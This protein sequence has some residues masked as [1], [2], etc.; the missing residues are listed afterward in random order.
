MSQNDAASYKVGEFDYKGTFNLNDSISA[1]L[2]LNDG[3]LLADADIQF[4][5]KFELIDENADKDLWGV[6]IKKGI[7]DA[8]KVAKEGILAVKEEKQAS[9]IDEY[10]VIKVTTTV[11]SQVEGVHDLVVYNYVLVQAIRPT[12]AEN[13]ATV[14]L[15]PLGDATFNLSY[16]TAKQIVKLDV[17]AFEDAIGGRDILTD[18]G[19]S[20][21]WPLYK[22]DYN[23]EKE[24]TGYSEAYDYLTT[25]IL[26]GDRWKISSI[27]MAC[28]TWTRY[29]KTRLNS[30]AR[31]LYARPVGTKYHFAPIWSAKNIR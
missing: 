12:A 11:K 19:T 3:V 21:V 6:T 27:C 23:T 18:K 2:D 28:K 10:A 4:E 15:S 20:I 29:I 8:D 24:L 25:P 16:K 13:V 9:A 5:Q 31:G 26:Y 17:R 14:K 1:A 30:T 22:A 7:F